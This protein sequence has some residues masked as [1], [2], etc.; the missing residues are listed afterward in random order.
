MLR[1]HDVKAVAPPE[2]FVGVANAPHPIVPHLSTKGSLLDQ[3]SS[4]FAFIFI[5]ILDVMN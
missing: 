1:K 3:L 2:F 4:V 5:N